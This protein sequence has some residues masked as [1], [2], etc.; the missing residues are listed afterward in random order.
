M[1]RGER[2]D[3]EVIEEELQK[4]RGETRGKTGVKILQIIKENPQVTIPGLSQATGLTIKGVEWN[5]KTLKKK[6]LLKRVGPA[7]G[8]YWEVVE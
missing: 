5:I 1:G 2:I 3:S 6:E 8:G 7:K 4:V